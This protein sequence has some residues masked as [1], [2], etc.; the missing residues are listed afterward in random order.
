MQRTEDQLRQALE[1]QE[2]L[3]H[4]MSHRVKN[5][6][7]LTAAMIQQ[8]LKGSATKEEMAEA[9]SGR[10]AA[11]ASAH[12]LVLRN[13]AFTDETIDLKELVAAVVKPHDHAKTREN[14]RIAMKGPSLTCNEQNASAI[15]LVFNE[16]ATNAV[17]Y[18]SL[19]G[20]LGSVDITWTVQEQCGAFPLD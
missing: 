5:L 16:L 13:A 15:A 1:K 3:T 9:L 6:F 20:A 7:A 10:L 4:E 14:S 12:S 17:K 18:G 2:T 19:S 11:L 8:S